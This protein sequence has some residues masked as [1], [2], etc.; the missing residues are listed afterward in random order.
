M[1]NGN[2]ASPIFPG[3]PSFTAG[4]AGTEEPPRTKPKQK[5]N[6]PT[7]SC[8]ECV[9]RKTKCDRGR[10]A[11]FCLDGRGKGEGCGEGGY[12]RLRSQ[13][14]Q[15]H[16]PRQVASA[17]SIERWS[18]GSQKTSS[19]HQCSLQGKRIQMC[20]KPA[21]LTF[22]FVF[23]STMP[24]MRKKTVKMRVHSRRGSSGIKRPQEH[25]RKQSTSDHQA[26]SKGSED[27]QCFE[28]GI[29]NHHR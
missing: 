22:C 8:L 11:S 2:G 23:R 17:P 15:A 18:R 9:E 6:K 19:K 13:S 7:L 14:P 29:A 1:S 26:H 21:M 3:G 24:R 10:L 27:Q 16:W 5:R 20:L 12:S 25:L 28:R 4:D